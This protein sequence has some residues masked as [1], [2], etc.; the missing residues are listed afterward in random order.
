M[1]KLNWRFHS[2]KETLWAR[3][4]RNKYC[5]HQRIN[6]VDS[7]KLPCSRVWKGMRKG[8]EVFNA[9]TKWVIGRDSNLRFW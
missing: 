8:Q 4:L 5:T 9:G 3:V 2:V 7:D 6:L 1:A